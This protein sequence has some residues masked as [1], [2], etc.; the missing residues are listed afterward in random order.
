VELLTHSGEIMSKITGGSHKL[1]DGQRIYFGGNKGSAYY[2]NATS[3]L[4]ITTT[5]GNSY[6]RWTSIP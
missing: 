5:S 1:K 6:I 4:V 3:T 2:D